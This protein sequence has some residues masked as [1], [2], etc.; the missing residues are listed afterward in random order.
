MGATVTESR[1]GRSAELLNALPARKK[2][3]LLVAAC[4]VAGTVVFALTWARTPEYGLLFSN[5]S[6]DDMQAIV[7]KLKERKQEYK[8][9]GNSIMVPEDKVYEL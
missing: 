5:L 6:Q 3:A 1:V 4:L 9:N 7:S 2:V 8:A